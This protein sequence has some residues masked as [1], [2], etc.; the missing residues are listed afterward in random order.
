MEVRGHNEEAAL[1]NDCG[2]WS[3]IAKDLEWIYKEK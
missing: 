2:V 1:I 3:E